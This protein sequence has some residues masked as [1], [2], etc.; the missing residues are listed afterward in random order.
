MTTTPNFSLSDFLSYNANYDVLIASNAPTASND[1]NPLQPRAFSISQHHLQAASLET[2]LS[3]IYHRI[4]KVLQ[5]ASF[6]H[7][8]I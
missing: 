7:R 2:S 5:M 3:Y 6:S 4:Q 1:L 8:M